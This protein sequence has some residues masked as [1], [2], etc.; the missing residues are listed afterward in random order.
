MMLPLSSSRSSTFCM[1]NWAYLASRTPSAMFSKSQ[2]SAI[3]VIS[4][5]PAMVVPP[6]VGSCNHVRY[7][8]PGCGSPLPPFP[9]NRP[10][11]FPR[12]P[13]VQP[14]VVA[15]PQL[16]GHRLCLLVHWLLA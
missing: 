15:H 5:G 14:L 12:A 4:G 13:F 3:F 8:P 11:E 2:N 16:G 1:S 6:V 9:Q 10:Q 7:V